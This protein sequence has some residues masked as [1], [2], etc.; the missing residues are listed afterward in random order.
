MVAA[1]RETT[2]P[3]KKELKGAVGVSMQNTFL[4]KANLESDE[5]RRSC[6]RFLTL[7][8]GR[9]FALGGPPPLYV[10]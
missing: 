5:N 9:V 3:M 2:K 10:L 8:S 1:N 6:H 4:F 7:T